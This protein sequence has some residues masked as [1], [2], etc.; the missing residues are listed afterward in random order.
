[1]KTS[2][3]NNKGNPSIISFI[4]NATLGFATAIYLLYVMLVFLFKIGSAGEYERFTTFLFGPMMAI[5]WIIAAAIAVSYIINNWF[6]LKTN[7]L[8]LI[9]LNIIL[10]IAT[11][12]IFGIASE[13]GGL[14]ILGWI[15][16]L[17]IAA[18]ISQITG[19]FAQ[20][21]LNRLGSNRVITANNNGHRYR[22]SLIG[23][24]TLILLVLSIF[25]LLQPI[26]Y[27]ILFSIIIFDFIRIKKQ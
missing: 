2:I 8:S 11:G 23:K 27:I 15:F 10:L 19:Y 14:Y 18:I 6:A 26:V 1:M 22:F 7:K 4:L 5:V 17:V 16:I 9:I 20:E 3:F 13:M 24:I 21:K 25:V 12:F